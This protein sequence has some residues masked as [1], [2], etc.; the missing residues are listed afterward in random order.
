M[1][2]R[3]FEILGFKT[4]RSRLADKCLSAKGAELAEDL[5]PEKTIKGAKRL[6]AETLEAESITISVASHPLIGFSDVTPELKRLKSQAGLNC[7]E[8][9]RVTQLLKA[10]RR[11][12]KG[13][14]PDDDGRLVLLPEMA[15]SLYY[16]DTI[17]SRIDDAI[18]S[19]EE[20]SDYASPELRNIRRRKAAENQAVRDKLSAVI[21]SRELS[22]YLQD[23]IITMR[24]G[25]FV[26]PV[27]SEYRGYIKGLVHGESSSGATV[28]IE[29]IGVVDANNKLRELENE[30]RREVERILMQLSDMLR[31]FVEDIEYDLEIMAYLDLVFAKAALGLEYEGTAADLTESGRL[32]IHNGR[33]PLI[34]PKKVIP[35]SMEI[36]AENTAMIITGP[37]TGGKTVTLKL[38]GLFALMSQSGMYIPAERSELPV[39]NG[40]YADIG[41]EQSIEQSLSTFSAHMRNIVFILRRAKKGSLVLLDELGAGTDPEEGAA[42][43]LAILKELHERGIKVLATTHYSELKAYALTTPG[44]IN[45]SMEFDTKSLMPTFKLIMGVAGASNAFYISKKLGLRR[46][47][48]DSAKKFMDEERLQFDSLL[49]EAQKERDKANRELKKAFEM[50]Q[51]AKEIDAKAKQLEKELEQKRERELEKAHKQAMEIVSKAQEETEQIISDVKKIRKMSESDTTRAVEKARKSLSGKK[52]NLRRQERPKKKAPAEAV[53]PSGILEGDTVHVNS[54]NADATVVKPP[55]AKGNVLVQAGI[56]TLNVKVSDLSKI[57]GKQKK[58]VMRTAKVNLTRKTVYQSI[59]LHGY[60]VEEGLLELDRYLDDAFLAGLKEVT[61]NHGKGTGVLRSAVQRYL[62]THPH[63]DKFRQGKYGEGEEGVTVVTL[64]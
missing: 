26:V 58:K 49:L 64:K 52:E 10:A 14:K 54:I 51:H 19:E 7:A 32:F 8:L 45:A 53:N 34:D 39:F 13:I 30:E 36:G 17:I 59:N 43:A 20:V 4:M 11:A 2:D 62:R 48:I 33:H 57:T 38:A 23:A 37:N 35:V 12:S 56:I 22:K 63:V 27:K 42:L 31:P 1:T 25:R 47:I 44:F 6:L 60:N 24:D 18:I 50:Q 15:E 46:E 9:L 5:K 21:R 28:F 40:V 3:V 16:D 41:D 29:P 61:I 55:D